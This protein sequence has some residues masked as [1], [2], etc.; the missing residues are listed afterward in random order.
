MV[1]FSPANSGAKSASLDISANGTTNSIPLSGTAISS[2]Y[3]VITDQS[4][5]L[6]VS[7]ATVT[8]NTS[9]TV[10]TGTDGSYT[11]GD[12]PAATYSIAVSK[13]GY[14]T[15]SK[16]GL[17]ISTTASAKADIL[18]PTVG[19]INIS[20]TKLPWASPNVPYSSRVMVAGGTAPY[21]FSRVYGILPTGLSLDTTTGTISGTP[22]GSGSSI[23][24][25]GVMDSVS[26]YSEKE[27]TIELL[28]PL[29]ITT[30]TLPSGQQGIGYSTSITATGG[31]TAY[32]FNV[33]KGP[34]IDPIKLTP[35]PYGLTLATNG[36]LHW[37]TARIRHLYFHHKTDRRNRRNNNSSLYTRYD[38]RRHSNA[39]HNHPAA[40]VSRNKLCNH[41]ISI[42]WSS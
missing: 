17:V 40:G 38:S 9:A 15:T 27:F 13:T 7:G 22:T 4:T 18:L 20:S 28:S 33:V 42:R 32:S 2:V 29:Q 1:G 35:L 8:L 25:I 6:P 21:T 36:A 10:T 37:H 34:I 14:Q 30:A 3:G 41:H 19:A 24:A 31:K 23:F 11:F 5:G 16:A 26:G 39:E 12:L